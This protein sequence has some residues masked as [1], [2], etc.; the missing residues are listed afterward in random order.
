MLKRTH[1]SGNVR[2][3]VQQSKARPQR[4]QRKQDMN[5]QMKL[6][7]LSMSKIPTSFVCTSWG[8]TDRL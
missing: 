2:W 8:P 7:F 3:S 4:K 5:M 6:T 1:G